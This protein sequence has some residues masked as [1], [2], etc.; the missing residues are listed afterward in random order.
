[1]KLHSFIL[2]FLPAVRYRVEHPYGHKRSKK[3]DPRKPVIPSVG[4]GFGGGSGRCEE[5]VHDNRKRHISLRSADIH[6]ISEDR[7]GM[8]RQSMAT[9]RIAFDS[10]LLL[11]YI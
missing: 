9:E 11:I 2:E 4:P 3:E 7:V 1:M 10:I 6:L 8:K 5:T